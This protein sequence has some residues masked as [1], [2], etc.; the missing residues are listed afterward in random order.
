MQIEAWRHNKLTQWRLEWS[1]SGNQ[2][3]LQ[4]SLNI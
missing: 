4:F 3:W 1:P 2:I